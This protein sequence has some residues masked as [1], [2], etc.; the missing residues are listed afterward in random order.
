[1]ITLASSS[2]WIAF[3]HS[4]APRSR[5]GIKPDCPAALTDKCRP[6][7]MVRARV[8]SSDVRDS[9]GGG[10]GGV[11]VVEFISLKDES[12]TGH[13]GG[14]DGRD[15]GGHGEAVGL[16]G[17]RTLVVVAVA[18]AAGGSAGTSGG[19]GGDGL[20]AGLVAVGASVGGNALTGR[21]GGVGVAALKTNVGGGGELHDGVGGGGA[22]VSGATDGV[23][24]GLDSNVGGRL[25]DGSVNR[26]EG[27]RNSNVGGGF[28]VGD[29]NASGI[30][31]SGGDCASGTGAVAAVGLVVTVV[32]VAVCEDRGGKAEDEAVLDLHVEG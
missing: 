32:R 13:G 22:N 1:L 2:R 28:D 26:D 3:F 29:N 31:G 8:F 27:S 6:S 4:K 25:Y 23:A 30:G 9:G 17:G 24:V 18:V 19:G 5:R 7:L 11:G 16:G 14:A 15:G 20:G 21:V 10:G 12:E